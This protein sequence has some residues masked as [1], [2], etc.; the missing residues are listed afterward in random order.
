MRK[1]I[2]TCLAMQV[3]VAGTSSRAEDAEWLTLFNGRDLEGWEQIGSAKWRVEDGVIVGGQEG[4]PRRGGL[5]ATSRE[6]Q[7]FEL[8]LEFMIDEHGKY[9]SGVYLRNDRNTASRTGYQV[10]IGRAA[11]EE[12]CGLYT[13][14]WLSKGDEHDAVRKKL[15]WN[16][17][18]IRARGGHIEVEL[19]GTKI[20]DFTDP[21]PT[22]KLL[23]K[24]V[25]GFQTY[26]AEGHSG[27][28]KFRN[29]RIRELQ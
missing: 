8:E 9:N 11:A 18:R 20:V 26:G 14:R 12:Y 29:I 16:H 6:F 4:D 10:N 28:V 22:E 3:C 15:E 2:I 23:Q 19:N 7:D 24:G 5:L 1:L 27:W 25:I 21:E 13:D 17:Y